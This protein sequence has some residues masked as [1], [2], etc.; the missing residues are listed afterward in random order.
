MTSHILGNPIWSSLRSSH[1]AV[2]TRVGDAARYAPIVAP[3]LAVA[4]ADADVAESIA[5]LLE[6]DETVYLLGVAPI[7]VVDGPEMV[8]L[9]EAHRP[10]VLVLT[11]LV[12]PHYFRPRTME[13]GRY[14]GIYQNGRLAAMAHHPRPCERPGPHHQHR[15]AALPRSRCPLPGPRRHRAA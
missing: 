14:F 12:Y 13:M 7:P 2:A 4:S 15:R 11:A 9:S 10:D 6:P 8:E 1:L 5:S 3:F